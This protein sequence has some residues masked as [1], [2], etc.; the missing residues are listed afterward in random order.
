MCEP[1]RE[2]GL[3]RCDEYSEYNEYDEYNE[4]DEFCHRVGFEYGEC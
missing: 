2:F 1:L 4:C 3:G